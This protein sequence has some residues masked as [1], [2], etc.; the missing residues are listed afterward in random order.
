MS[1][2]EPRN[3]T[4]VDLEDFNTAEAQPKEL[5]IAFMNMINFY[6]YD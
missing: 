6:E 4:P 5:K 3:P 2:L 1:S